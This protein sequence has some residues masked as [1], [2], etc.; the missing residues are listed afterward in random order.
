MCGITGILAYRGGRAD[1]AAVVTMRDRMA[2]RGPDGVGLWQSADGR[3]AFGH[4]RLAFIDL[5][6]IADQPIFLDR[7]RMAIIFNGEIY[8]YRALRAELVAQGHRFDTESDTEV[9]LHLY[10]RYG[11]A[12]LER[13]RGMY[14]IAIWD[15]DK[16][17]LFLARDPFGIKP[18]YYTDDGSEF[19][20]ASQV[21]ALIAGGADVAPDPAGHAGFFLWGNVP[22]P[23][24]LYRAIKALPA[25]H[26]LWVDERGARAP[27]RY[28]TLAGLF[29]N[30]PA[31]PASPGERRALLRDA[32]ADSVSHHLI[33]DVP[34]GVF[35]SAGRDSTTI[36]ALAVEA[37]ARDLHT[38]TLGFEEYRGTADDETVLAEAVARQRGTCHETRWVHGADFAGER[39]A[40]LDAMDQPSI[41][42][43]NT[44]FVAKA[45]REAGLKA[46]LSGL[47]GDEIFAGYPS[48]AQVPKLV[49][50]F[51]PFGTGSLFGRALRAASGRW[52]GRVTSPKYAGLVEYGGGWGGAYLLRRSLFMP[53]EVEA[54]LP[55]DIARAGL[56]ELDTI[57]RLDATAHDFATPRL[58][59]MALELEW[60]MRHQLL[61][62]ADWAGMAHSV[63]IRVPFVDVEFVRRIAPLLAS[64]TPPA[65]ADMAATPNMPLPDAVLARAKTGFQVPV[66]RWL[67]GDQEA[68]GE[69]GLRGWARAAYGAMPGALR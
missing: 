14:T 17:G 42:G 21:K 1:P 69:R 26:T 23:R 8:N 9:I 24:T 37:G 49:G 40:L 62:D 7:D 41:D 36:T 44:Y 66:R 28:F 20:F 68:S 22:D 33:A 60:Y 32:L 56:A 65:K 10:D 11:P 67:T 39:A 12:M 46:A 6:D 51:G 29:A 38:L 18:L 30:A 52:I 58:K 55:P 45:T 4:R 50:A 63:E 43:V 16:R 64:A 35:L 19:R 3:F 59:V 13:L 57:A 15:R 27:E 5:R 25:G 54:L 34:V 48:F 53:W 31:A 2:T 61:R 47:G